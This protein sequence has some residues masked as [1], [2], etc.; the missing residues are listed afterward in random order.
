MRL[1]HKQPLQ[2]HF[3]QT[4]YKWH[5]YFWWAFVMGLIL[6]AMTA[7]SHTGFPVAGDPDTPVHWAIL[8]LAVSSVLFF[9][10]VFVSCRIVITLWKVLAGKSPLENRL[11]KWFY[12][13]HG[14]YWWPFVFLVVAHAAVAYVHVGIWPR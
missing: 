7:F 5:A 9:F 10:L 11:F 1:L 13:Q 4:F 2:S 14:L 8:G 3:F 12:V 6:H